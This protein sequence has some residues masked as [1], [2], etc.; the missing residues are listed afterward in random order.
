MYRALI[1]QGVDVPATTL[2]FYG[3]RPRATSASSPTADP[4]WARSLGY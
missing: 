4:G 2:D 1:E 3:K